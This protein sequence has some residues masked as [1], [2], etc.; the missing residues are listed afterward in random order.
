MSTLH[1]QVGPAILQLNVEG[2]TRPKCEIIQNIAYKNWISVIL[3]QETHSTSD[4]EIKITVSLWL[5]LSIIINTVSR[6]RSGMTYQ[7]NLQTPANLTAKRSDLLL[8]S[9]MN[10]PF[11][12]SHVVS[13]NFYCRTIDKSC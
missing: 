1:E 8:L 10:L 12:V 11:Y 7:Q 9:T 5:E 6:H 2:F 3:L 13:L 4:D